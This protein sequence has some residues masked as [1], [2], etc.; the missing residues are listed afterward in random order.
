[1]PFFIQSRKVNSAKLDFRVT[2]FSEVRSMGR[3]TPVSPTL[4][5][6]EWLWGLHADALPSTHS[7]QV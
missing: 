5:A 3:P 1:M 4:L 7:L 6:G 2:E